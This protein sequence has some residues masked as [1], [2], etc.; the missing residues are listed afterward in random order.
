[1][2]SITQI[3]EEINKTDPKFKHLIALSDE[4]LT[5]S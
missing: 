4:I 2:N 5:Y 3:I 1:M